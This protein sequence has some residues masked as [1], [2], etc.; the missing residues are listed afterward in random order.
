ME[1]ITQ[2]LGDKEQ[3]EF[4]I[5]EGLNR[6]QSALREAEE[7]QALVR[8]LDVAGM[9]R[10]EQEIE[11]EEA[12]SEGKGTGLDRAK[13]EEEIDELEAHIVQVR[14]QLK[15]S[16]NA[17]DENKRLEE[18][19]R[20][21]LTQAQQKTQKIKFQEETSEGLKRAQSKAEEAILTLELEV[22]E[23]A[24]KAPDLESEVHAAEKEKRRLQEQHRA[25]REKLDKEVSVTRKDAEKL[26]ELEG[27]LMAY[28][29]S[30]NEENLRKNLEACKAKQEEL[31]RIHSETK[32]LNAALEDKERGEANGLEKIRS[33]EAQIKATECAQRIASLKKQLSDL[34]EDELAD[35]P[36]KEALEEKQQKLQKEVD[37]LQSTKN[38]QIGRMQTLKETIKDLKKKLARPD[39]KNIDEKYKMKSI[40]LQTTKCARK[41]LEKYYD[42][43]DKALMRYHEIKMEEI[44]KCIK[45]IWEV[46]Y[47]GKDI[48]TIQ[49]KADVENTGNKRSHNYRLV[50][51]HQHPAGALA[52]LDMR[53]R[54]S[55]GQKVLASLVVRLALADAFCHNC[56]ILALDEP[57]SNLDERNIK[58]FTEALSRIVND[59]KQQ[60]ASFQLVVISHDKDFI[61]DLARDTEVPVYYRVEKNPNSQSSVI[62]KHWCTGEF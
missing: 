48:D 1:D 58:G 19:R 3:E 47:Q 2:Q 31:Q 54:C 44:N 46:T 23:L 43:L 18:D 50:M 11:E 39:D 21:N 34:E 33:L 24:Q 17:K 20:R 16:R 55:A 25:E 4:Q 27:E 62:T 15:Q 45:E 60:N 32:D 37:R 56:G 36:D 38:Q 13:I 5:D 61:N 7:L 10:L 35:Y 59:R 30:N 14:E 40:E 12:Q 9:L 26:S 29:C 8:E 6:G 42:A 57:T 22:R 52:E 49:I 41:D 28:R 51:R 53:G